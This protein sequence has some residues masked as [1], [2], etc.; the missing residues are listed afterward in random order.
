MESLGLV[1]L[2]VSVYM[3]FH[4]MPP[5]YLVPVAICGA[6]LYWKMRHMAVLGMLQRSGLFKTLM[7]LS[8]TQYLTWLLFYGIGRGAGAV[9]S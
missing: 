5:I 8:I 6:M 9:F 3:G 2:G 4:G 1:L 7:F